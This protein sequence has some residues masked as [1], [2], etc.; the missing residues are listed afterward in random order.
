[1]SP[2]EAVAR[3]ASHVAF[4]VVSHHCTNVRHNNWLDFCAKPRC[5]SCRGPVDGLFHF[6]ETVHDQWVIS[7]SRYL[8]IKTVRPAPGA[9]SRPRANPERGGEGQPGAP[10]VEVANLPAF[11]MLTGM[12]LSP[13]TN[14]L[15]R[16]D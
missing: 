15:L 4:R 2:P 9:Q 10:I 8:L 5:R 7:E 16:V 14:L 11:I 1:M 6:L 12:F 13:F 3:T